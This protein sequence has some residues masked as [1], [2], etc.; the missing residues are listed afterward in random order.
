MPEVTAEFLGRLMHYGEGSR[1]DPVVPISTEAQPEP[2]GAVY[3]RRAAPGIG[4]TLRNGLRK[5]T[6]RLTGL[7]IDLGS[8]PHSRYFRNLNTS[9]DWLRYSHD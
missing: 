5:V 6:G 3:R 9:Q 1:S 4:R 7:D 2:L 8:A